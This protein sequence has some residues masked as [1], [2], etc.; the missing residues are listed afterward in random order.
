MYRPVQNWLNG[1]QCVRDKIN[2]EYRIQSDL[3]VLRIKK[4]GE[5]IEKDKERSKGKGL[6]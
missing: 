5:K 6:K 4:M 2:M 3:N 1:F